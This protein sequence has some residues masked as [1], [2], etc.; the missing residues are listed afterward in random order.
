MIL[1]SSRG[2][3][4][5]DLITSALFDSQL[6]PPVT[7]STD[8]GKDGDSLDTSF[9]P[10]LHTVRRSPPLLC[11]VARIMIGLSVFRTDGIMFVRHGT[12]SCCN[13]S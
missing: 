8:N 5:L 11:D 6:N 12:R 13:A 3:S 10:A 2:I 1:R 4:A 7:G 9:A